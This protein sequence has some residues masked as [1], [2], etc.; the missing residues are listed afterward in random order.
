MDHDD[1]QE[2][3]VQMLAAARKEA[4][5]RAL[6]KASERLTN[7]TNN[8]SKLRMEFFDRL[9]LL[10]GGTISLTLTLVGLLQRVGKPTHCRLLLFFSWACF[11]ASLLL[12]MVRNWR[13]HDRLMAAEWASYTFVVHEHLSAFVQ[14][15]ESLGISAADSTVQSTL[16]KGQEVFSQQ[17]AQQAHLDKKTKILGGSAM[18]STFMGYLL[19][20]WFAIVNAAA[21]L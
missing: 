8:T 1:G 21:L 3:I 5:D 13:E 6:E 4:A 15:V 10:D 7:Q 9:I 20:L 18:A 2:E 11:M 19:L 17:Q 14:Q 12:G 16:K